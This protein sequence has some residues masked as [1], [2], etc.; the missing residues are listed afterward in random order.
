MGGTDKPKRVALLEPEYP[1]VG[2]PEVWPFKIRV[3]QA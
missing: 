1:T 3:G 2:F